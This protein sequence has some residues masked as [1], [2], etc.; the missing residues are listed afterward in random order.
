[1]IF[2]S[3]VFKCRSVAFNPFSCFGKRIFYIRE[4]FFGS[5]QLKVAEMD[6]RRAGP[7]PNMKPQ[8]NAAPER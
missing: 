8:E 3:R 5:R 4:A 7:K 6:G 2:Y 1:M